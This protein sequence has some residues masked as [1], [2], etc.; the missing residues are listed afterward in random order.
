MSPR[1]NIFSR[2]R[3]RRRF[4][5]RKFWRFSRRRWR[6]GR[7]FT[8]ALWASHPA[9]SIPTTVVLLLVIWLTVNWLYHVI[10]KPTEV[11]FPLDNALDKD[12]AETWRQYGPLFQEH[13]TAVITA[14]LL[15]ALAQ[16]EGSGNPVAR[17][18]WRWRPSWNPFEWYQPASSAVGMYQ[19]TDGT[20]QIAKHYCIHDHVVVED[21]A[22]HDLRSCWFN[23][24]YT[25][26]LPSHAIELTAALLDR[27]VAN[28]IGAKSR[29]TGTLQRKQELAAVIHLCGA[30]AGHDFAM[31]GFRPSLHQRCGDHDVRIYLAKV[32]E[33]KRQFTRL[34][35]GNQ[36]YTR[37]NKI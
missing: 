34:A 4:T 18:Y 6:E 33:M 31:R 30:G 37:S 17:T 5:I 2:R 29:L 35:A 28:A 16:V 15:A 27:Q 24:L 10:N 12:L 13:A 20:F 21:G 36:R 7:A 14:E 8:R 25:R 3:R 9:V 11:F 22:W 26:V 19:I 23:S 1:P 32:N